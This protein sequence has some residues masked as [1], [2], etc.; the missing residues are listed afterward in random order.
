MVNSRPAS[1][2]GEPVREKGRGGEGGGRTGGREV[3]REG[4]RGE[5]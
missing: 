1:I 5:I 3:W 2:P 4:R